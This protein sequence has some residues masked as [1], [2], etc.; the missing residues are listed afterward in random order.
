MYVDLGQASWHFNVNVYLG[1]NI[2]K[3]L[4]YFSFSLPFQACNL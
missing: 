2:W 1:R 4:V 3:Q